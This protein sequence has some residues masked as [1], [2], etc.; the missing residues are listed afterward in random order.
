MSVARI[1]TAVVGTATVLGTIF[2]GLTY[3]SPPKPTAKQ[4]SVPT[5][6][7]LIKAESLPLEAN[8]TNAS[9]PETFTLR[10][11]AAVYEPPTRMHFGQIAI[12]FRTRNSSVATVQVWARAEIASHDRDV[13]GWVIDAGETICRPNPRD[14]SVIPVGDADEDLI[15]YNESGKVTERSPVIAPRKELSFTVR[16]QCEDELKSGAF[17]FSTI[18]LTFAAKGARRNVYFQSSGL[19]ML[20]SN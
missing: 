12:R 8:W 4:S 11:T 15:R 6:V 10:S 7:G 14:F 9:G 13:E 2:A 17:L 1:G 16:F 5:H 3:C 20:R 19:R 18:R